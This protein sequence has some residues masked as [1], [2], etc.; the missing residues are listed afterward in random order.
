[1]HVN[2]GISNGYLTNLNLEGLQKSKYDVKH[3]RFV[4]RGKTKWGRFEQWVHSFHDRRGSPIVI[5]APAVVRTF[6]I[7]R[8]TGMVTSLFIVLAALRNH[9]GLLVVVCFYSW[10][11]P[12]DA[13]KYGDP[14]RSYS[15]TNSGTAYQTQVTTSYFAGS[16]EMHIPNKHRYKDHLCLHRDVIRVGK[17]KTQS[18]YLV[19][20]MGL[21]NEPLCE[22][23]GT[24]CHEVQQ[25]ARI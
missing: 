15:L 10:P 1:M 9:S 11:T 24:T 13:T 16:G 4:I 3:G 14:H 6:N 20:F 18:D 21:C 7:Q 2:I 5:N 22:K 8:A 19:E 25:E 23:G 12:A 17:L